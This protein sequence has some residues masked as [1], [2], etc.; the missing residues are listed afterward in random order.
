MVGNS[1]FLHITNPQL[2]TSGSKVEGIAQVLVKDRL[3]LE[4][5]EVELFGLAKSKNYQY[6]N[7]VRISGQ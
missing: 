7:G 4:A 1:L 5:V 3:N 6:N 2:Y